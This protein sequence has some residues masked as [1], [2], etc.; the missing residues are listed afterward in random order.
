MNSEKCLAFYTFPIGFPL[1]HSTTAIS[2][3]IYVIPLRELQVS[4]SRIE[5]RRMEMDSLLESRAR[6][7][8]ILREL[9]RH[10]VA[11]ENRRLGLRQPPQN[12]T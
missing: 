5:R 2:M 3:S 12:E 11:L 8:A 6:R 10:E 9:F 4:K 1:L 7:T